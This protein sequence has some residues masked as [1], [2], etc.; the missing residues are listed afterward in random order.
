MKN[1]SKIVMI[2][3][4]A[5]SVAGCRT[6]V[7]NPNTI[8]LENAMKS[9]GQG[10]ADMRTAEGNGRTGLYPDSAEVTFNISAASTN[11]K[12]LV[13]DLKA[14][15]PAPQIPVSADGKLDLSHVYAT[16]R[17]NQITIKFKNILA[18]NPADTL[19]KNP[20][21]VQA[22]LNIITNTAY[23]QS[24]LFVPPANQ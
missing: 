10:F 4:V 6:A 24:I 16:Q 17:A 14:S 2:G 1:I 7:P 23:S 20:A 19:M 15:S 9:I 8:T 18:I 22:M 3:C 21:D 13:V 5:M 11:S 12:S